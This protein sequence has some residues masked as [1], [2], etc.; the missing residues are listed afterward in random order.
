MEKIIKHLEK[1]ALTGTELQEALEYCVNV[2][3]YHELEN[4]HDI[5]QLMILS[6]GYRARAAV[7][8]YES[9]YNNGH[10]TCLLEYPDHY[11]FFDPYGSKKIDE[12][13]EYSSFDD[14]QTV[15]LKDLLRAQRKPYRTSLT[16]YQ[17][18]GE[19]IN[20]CGRH[21][22]AR[23]KM[24]DLT[25]QEYKNVMHGNADE[26]VVLLTMLSTDLP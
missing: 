13:L 11:L 21:C 17:K 6:N 10:Y 25:E 1:K 16:K 15:H 12:E 20:T 8:L 19:G 26:K 22:I 3:A 7:I 9:S 23:I 24:Y 5:N 14:N 18:D 2:V 4:M